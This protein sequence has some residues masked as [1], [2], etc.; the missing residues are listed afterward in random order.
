MTF[1]CL[2]RRTHQSSAVTTIM[3]RADMKA[4]QELNH[5]LVPANTSFAGFENGNIFLE[6]VIGEIGQLN[7]LSCSERGQIG[8]N[9]CFQINGQ[10][11]PGIGSMKF[12]ARAAGKIDFSRKVI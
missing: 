11:E 5:N 1:L 7:A 12:P 3:S 6:Q 8:L 2:I 9:I 10:I 4:Q